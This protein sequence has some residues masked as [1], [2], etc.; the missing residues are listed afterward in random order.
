MKLNQN[1]QSLFD[2]I[3]P[4]LKQTLDLFSQ[5]DSY[6]EFFDSSHPLDSIDIDLKEHK[7]KRTIAIQQQ[8]L[9]A[10]QP[11]L[12]MAKDA[13]DTLRPYKSGWYVFRDLFQL[14]YGVK[15]T[16][17]GTLQLLIVPIYF[18]AALTYELLIQK[19]KLLPLSMR[20]SNIFIRSASWTLDGVLTTLRGTL[21]IAT[22]PLGFGKMAL[23]GIID[24]F[25][26]PV[27]IETT[28]QV[29][30]ILGVIQQKSNL[31]TL[32]FREDT[33]LQEI[34]I[35]PDHAKE[36]KAL[37]TKLH[38]T[39]HKLLERGVIS[40]VDQNE[41]RKKFDAAQTESDDIAI[42]A[43]FAL[44]QEAQEKKASNSRYSSPT[45]EL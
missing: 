25:S 5:N 30:K 39:Y 7:K 22:F 12:D 2:Y 40:S 21:Q 42:I 35:D 32:S 13:R 36:Q 8:F 3:Y 14:Y 38:S 28:P 45:R 4:D 19:K 9:G 15:N 26:E 11:L 1:Y 27:P 41:E 44:F 24:A 33:G 43:Y 23:R 37:M 18:L 29:K 17:K 16:L 20:L 34:H 6:Q 10:L 31:A